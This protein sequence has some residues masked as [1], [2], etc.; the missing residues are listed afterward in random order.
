[1]CKIKMEMTS[2]AKVP[3]QGNLLSNKLNGIHTSA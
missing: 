3:C 2:E 1:M